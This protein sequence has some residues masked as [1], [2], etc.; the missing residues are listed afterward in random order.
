MSRLREKMFEEWKICLP[1]GH[2]YAF[3]L[4]RVWKVKTWQLPTPKNTYGVHINYT[5]YMVSHI[6]VQFI[7]VYNKY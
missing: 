3:G 4:D 2:G 1:Q 7:H 5:Q 6:Y